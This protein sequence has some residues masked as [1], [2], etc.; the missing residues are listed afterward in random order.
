MYTFIKTIT[1]EINLAESLF[2]IIENYIKSIDDDI[3]NS[4]LIDFD[5]N[6]CDDDNNEDMEISDFEDELE[7]TK[8]STW[9]ILTAV[10]IFFF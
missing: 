5:S 10:I 6:V 1:V 4:E 2:E 8:V 7:E 3:E 9:L